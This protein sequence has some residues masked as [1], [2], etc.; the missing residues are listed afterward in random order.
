MLPGV[1]R[2]TAPEWRLFVT[3]WRQIPPHTTQSP[4][5]TQLLPD[6]CP[7][8]TWVAWTEFLNPTSVA[9]SWR[10]QKPRVGPPTHARPPCPADR[11]GTRARQNPPTGPPARW[12]P[13]PAR[14]PPPATPP[15]R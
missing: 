15:T 14:P 1:A 8:S 12:P 9:N 3:K 6:A 13:G 4:A 5:R 10:G 2:T 11:R 7:T